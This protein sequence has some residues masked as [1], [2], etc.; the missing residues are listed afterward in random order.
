MVVIGYWTNGLIYEDSRGQKVWANYLSEVLQFLMTPYLADNQKLLPFKFCWDVDLLANPLLQLLHPDQL[1][2]LAETEA[3]TIEVDGIKY[4]IWYPR[5]DGI[6]TALAI[7]NKTI[8][9]EGNESIFW[10][11]T[12]FTPEG[13]EAPA[14]ALDTQVLGE[15]IL[16]IFAKK[17]GYQPL[18]HS[19]F[20]PVNV[21]KPYLEKMNLP[22][23]A[24]LP[25]KVANYAA[26][27]QMAPWVEA[28]KL[29]YWE[30]AWDVDLS[31][32]YASILRDLPD[33]RHGDWYE[34]E[35]FQPKALLGYVNCDVDIRPEVSLHPILLDMEEGAAAVTGRQEDI[36]LTKELINL[37]GRW[38][39][40]TSHIRSGVWWFPEKVIRYPLMT[41]IDKLMAARYSQNG[42]PHS[43]ITRFLAKKCLVGLWGYVARWN[44]QAGKDPDV[45]YNPPWATEIRTRTS[46]KDAELIYRKKLVKNVIGIS[47]DGFLCDRDPELTREDEAAGWKVSGTGPALVASQNHSWF[48]EK[49][50]EGKTIDE[51]LQMV[52]ASPQNGSWT[53]EWKR[54]G[55]LGD[56]VLREDFSLLGEPIECRSTLHLRQDW[57]RAC[58][59]VPK[60]GKSLLSRKWES[61]PYTIEEVT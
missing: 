3:V 33:W 12:S 21:L 46:I 2:Q 23:L 40:G 53:W 55:T 11:L 44:W 49:R 31:N 15:R 29:G 56:C 5:K 32:A 14:D 17:I 41:V 25:P 34:S 36:W 27:C 47:V 42:T 4:R 16:E 37:V 51:V 45:F 9:T 30:K 35:H 58:P 38:K 61:R 8:R 18:P 50:P 26:H 43:I 59:K 13:M 20:S 54:T 22:R 28:H 39:L 10:P 6:G 60:T 7:T 19:M 24:D 48:G 1:K 52:H 57:N